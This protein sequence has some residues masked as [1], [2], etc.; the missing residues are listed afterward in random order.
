MASEEIRADVAAYDVMRAIGSL[1]AY[2]DGTG[3]YDA[4]AMVHLLI[5]GLRRQERQ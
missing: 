3:R 4:R 5:A 1:C 2:S